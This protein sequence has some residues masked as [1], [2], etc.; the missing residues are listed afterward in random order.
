MTAV[1][2]NKEKC[3]LSSTAALQSVKQ[4]KD[5]VRALQLERELL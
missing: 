2:K 4:A 1:A 5:V 3:H